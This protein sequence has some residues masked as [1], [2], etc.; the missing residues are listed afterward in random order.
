MISHVAKNNKVA[1]NKKQVVNKN[2][3]VANKNKLAANNN[4]VVNK[5][6][7]ESKRSCNK[8]MV[9]SVNKQNNL[10]LVHAVE[11]EDVAQVAEQLIMLYSLR[12]TR[13]CKDMFL[14]LIWD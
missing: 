10:I 3:L 7:M 6:M 13:S 9:K 12:I 5:K 11:L 4:N 8:G 2:N 1:E 14:K